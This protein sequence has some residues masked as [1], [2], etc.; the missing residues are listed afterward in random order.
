MPMEIREALPEDAQAV[1]SVLRRSISELC[2]ADHHD[3][4]KI[5][6]LWL[7]NKTP[8]IVAS[9]IRNPNNTTLLAV[10]G[11]TILAVGQVTLAGEIN[12]NY[13]SP[14]ARFRGVSRTLMAA[15]EARALANGATRCT[16]LSTE[17]AHRFY[18]SGGYVDVGHPVGKFGT[19]ASYP[20]AK[21]LAPPAD[22]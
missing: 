10:E 1:C 12:L 4:P 22:A 15:L 11:S 18:L 17:T 20:M 5:L 6:G 8:D 9:W 16:L 14:E 19:D 2:A 7:A 3:D 13:V 21:E